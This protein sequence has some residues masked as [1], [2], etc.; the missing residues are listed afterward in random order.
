MD[1]NDAFLDTWKR[2]IVASGA[3][4]LFYGAG[5]H[6]QISERDRLAPK[7]PE[8]NKKITSFPKSRAAFIAALVSFHNSE[9]GAKLAKK[10]GCNGFGD[11]ALSLDSTQRSIIADLLIF[12]KGW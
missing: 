9:E 1:S 4:G 12:Y 11:L 2:G 7:T 6:D 5:L 3:P 8:I 10:V